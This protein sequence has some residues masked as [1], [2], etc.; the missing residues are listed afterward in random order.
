MKRPLMILVAFLAAL[1]VSF[2][3][4]TWF[5]NRGD[6]PQVGASVIG[7]AFTAT[8]QDGAR[9]NEAIL[10]GKPTL[11]FFGF[12]HCP[13]ICPTT[14]FD[15]S[16]IF[17]A[18][19]PDA[20]KAQGVFVTV[21][22]E[23]D[24][25]AQMKLYLSSFDPHILGLSGTAEETAAI[26]KAYRVYARKVPLDGKDYTMDHTALVYLIDRNGHFVSTFNMKRK[27]A[28]AAADLRRYF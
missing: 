9:V 7:G 4:V 28:D 13:D 22:P 21:D 25:P 11:M 20:D 24:D 14:L 5:F 2:S 26:L 15:V 8:R 1:I 3:A 19:G 18:L 6:G 17:R 12:T 23:R 10:K 16:E 27:P